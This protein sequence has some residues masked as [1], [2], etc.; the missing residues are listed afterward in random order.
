MPNGTEYIDEVEFYLE[1]GGTTQNPPDGDLFVC[2]PKDFETG[3]MSYRWPHR[4]A[5]WSLDPYGA[6][7]LSHEDAS[8]L[9]FPPI[10]LMT[11]VYAS[12]WDKTVYAGLRK[13]DECKGFNPESQDVAKELGYPLYEVSDGEWIKG[14]LVSPLY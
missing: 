8:S 3:P 9:G 5:Y 1:I 14:F 13:F 11:D 2:S 4:P 10:T 12:F 7:P 6:N